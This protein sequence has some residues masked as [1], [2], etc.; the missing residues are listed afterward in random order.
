MMHYERVRTDLSQ[1]ERTEIHGRFGS[2]KNG[3]GGSAGSGSAGKGY[4]PGGAEGVHS[5]T[6]YTGHGNAIMEGQQ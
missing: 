6:D 4:L 1:A 2:R 5:G 3:A